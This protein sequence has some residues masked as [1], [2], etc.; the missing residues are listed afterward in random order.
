MLFS[1]GWA[2]KYTPI[3]GMACAEL[4]LDGNTQFDISH[5]GIVGKGKSL[6]KRRSLRTTTLARRL[7]F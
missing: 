3:I 6:E 4:A 7:P 2:F 5:F 1:A